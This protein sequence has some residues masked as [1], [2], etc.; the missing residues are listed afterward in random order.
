MSKQLLRN[1]H[2]KGTTVSLVALVAS[3]LASDAIASSPAAELRAHEA[4]LSAR[5]MTLRERIRLSAPTLVH[6]LPPRKKLVQ[7]RNYR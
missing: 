4:D 2:V 3:V 1:P 7:W 5:V 6:G